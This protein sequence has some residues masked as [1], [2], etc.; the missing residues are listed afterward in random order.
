MHVKNVKWHFFCSVYLCY[1]S[2]QT[3]NS[4]NQVLSAWFRSWRRSLQTHEISASKWSQR[5]LPGRIVLSTGNKILVI[6]AYPSLSSMHSFWSVSAK[7]SSVSSSGCCLIP[8]GF[9][10]CLCLKWQ[11][12]GEISIAC[13]E[14]EAAVK[15]R[16]TTHWGQG[17]K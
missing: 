4:N 6:R 13:F 3:P 5:W 1:V 14:R 16:G 2:V 8:T 10:T 11:K 9:G 12:R 17:G 7:F 15:L